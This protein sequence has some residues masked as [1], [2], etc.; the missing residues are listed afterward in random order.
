MV[1]AINAPTVGNTLEAFVHVAKAATESTSPTFGPVGGILGITNNPSSISSNSTF[2][3]SVA[4]LQVTSDNAFKLTLKL[5]GL[6]AR[7]AFPIF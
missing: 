6:L 1:G 4:S 5:L 3:F 2:A 7:G